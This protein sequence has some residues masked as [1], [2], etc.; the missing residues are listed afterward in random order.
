M[1]NKI[2]VAVDTVIL[3]IG[4]KGM[5]VFLIK[6]KNEPYE[7][8]WALPGAVVQDTESL[9]DAAKRVIQQRVGDKRIHVKQ[10]YSFGEVDRDV[11]GRSISV[12]YFALLSDKKL[13]KPMLNEQYSEMG[14]YG[15]DSLPKMAFDHADILKTARIK[16]TFMLDEVGVVSK[17]LPKKFTLSELQKVHEIL[18]GKKIDK[19]N[20]VKKTKIDDEIVDTGEMKKG[21]A[22]RPAKLFRFR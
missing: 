2:I 17:L 15:V 4:D 14:W 9:D 18:S 1:V 5:E 6:I 11:R 10:L 19:R 7:G 12:A 20:F 16:L 3:A 13:I 22:F 8:C 21:E